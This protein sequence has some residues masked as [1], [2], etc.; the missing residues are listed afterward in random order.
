MKIGI[1]VHFEHSFF[2]NGNPTTAIS[3]A[4]AL[5]TLG[6]EPV[7]ININGTR[8]WYDDVE[9]LSKLYVRKN[10]TELKADEV[11][12]IV[13]DIDGYI[14][15]KERR[16]ISKSVVIFIRKSFF[17]T[18]SESCV[19]PKQLPKQNLYDCDMLWTW[20]HFGAEDA[21]LLE[22]LTKKPVV[23]IPFTWSS[24]PV[25][26]FGSNHPSWIS[27]SQKSKEEGW[28]IH[29]V[30]I[31]TS[32]T[33]NCTVPMVG[34][35]YA[36]THSKV[37]LLPVNI[38]S[39]THIE[40]EQFFKDNILAHCR[41]EGLEFKFLGR[42]RI[43]DFRNI[44]KS[45]VVLHTRFLSFKNVLLD[46]IWNG[47]PCIHNSPFIKSLGMG[48]ERSYYPDNSIVG[49]T[50][51]LN[52]IDEDY[53]NNSGIFTLGRLDEIR[54]MFTKLFDPIQHKKVW[55][56]AIGGEN[57]YKEI[58]VGFSDMY[59]GFNPEYNF[60]TVMLNEAGRHLHPPVR[61]RGIEINQINKT[62]ENIDILIAG[63]FYIN[64]KGVPDNIPKF[65]ITG[66]NTGCISEN[67]NFGFSKDGPKSIRFPLWIQY[68]DWFGADQDK[69]KNPRGLPI[70]TVTTTINADLSKKTK[71]CAFVV[72]NPSNSI[73][74]DAFH[75]LSSYKHVDSAG[76][77][78]NNMGYKIHSDFPGGGGGE[79]KKVEFLKDY[80][81]VITYEN[82]KGSGYVTEKLLA[83]KAAGCVPIYWGADEVVDD[84]P[85][86]SFINVNTKPIGAELI[87]AVRE[88]DNDD[89]KW[90]AMAKI[91]A[92]NAEKCR[93]LI[94][95]VARTILESIL[96]KSQLADLPE[97]LG[98]ANTAEANKSGIARGDLVAP[99]AE[100][101][102]GDL[103]A[104]KPEMNNV[105]TI[106][107][108]LPA[109]KNKLTKPN[110]IHNW[111]KKILLV[112]F[113]TQKYVEPLV[114]WFTSV[115][116]RLND[117]VSAR[118]Y[119]GKD[120]DNQNLNL[121]RSQYP[122]VEFYKVPEDE[123]VSSQF[124]DLWEAQHFAWKLWI[125]QELVH[126][127]ELE[128]TLVWYMDAAS[129]IVRWPT[130][131]FKKTAE[132][133]L[134]M[135]E[136]PEQKNDQWC[137]PIFCSKLGVTKEELGQ[138]QI[139][140]GIMSFIGGAIMPC[141]LFSEAWVLGQQRAIIV[142]P[143]WSGSLP[144]GR[145]YGHRHDQ[146]ILSIL[147]LRHKVPV[148]P[149][150]S[151]Y[152]DE[153]IRRTFKSGACLYIHRGNFKLN[154]NFA[155]RIGDAHI[156]NLE[157]RGDRI[158]RFKENHG[159]WRK[160]ICLRP[161]YDGLSLQLTP[162]IAKLFAPND[163]KWKKSIAGCALSHLSLWSE[164]ASEH[165]SCENYLILEDDVKF[166]GDWLATWNEASK[167]IPTDYDVLYLGGILPPNK[168][169]YDSVV[170]PV[171]RFWGRIKP[172]QLFGQGEPMP[173]FHFCNYSYI[174]SRNAAKK[175]VETIMKEG[176]TTS[177]D[178]MICNRMD[179]KHYVL[180][181]LVAGCYQ[182]DDPK[183]S[184]S[185]FNN[186]DRVD[187]FDSDLWNNDERF[188]QAEI[189]TALE[190]NSAFSISQALSDGKIKGNMDTKNRIFTV[191]EDK[192]IKGSL[193]EYDWLES[194]FGPLDKQQSLPINHEP[195][196]NSPIFF[197]K[198][199][200]FNEYMH[201][202][203]RY[204]AAGKTFYA[205]HISDELCNDPIEWYSLCK[206]VIRNY[207][208]ADTKSFDNVTYIPLGPCRTTK[209]V[210]DVKS[211]N[212]AWSFF[213]TG[214]LGRELKL[215]PLNG[216][217]PNKKVFY[218]KW[219]DSSQLQASEY[220]EQ[221][222]KT[223]FMPCPVGNNP[224]TFR[225]Y[226]AL[227]HGCIP[228]Y[229]RER[230]DDLFIKMLTS[231]LPIAIM[232]SWEAS[233]KFMVDNFQNTS[234]LV[235]YRIKLLEAW[236]VWKKKIMSDIKD[237]FKLN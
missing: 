24:K 57:N 124:P 120:V 209:L 208:R 101:L 47:I 203:S 189:Q 150:Y 46:C 48:L 76:Q 95:K 172:N 170:E 28:S 198:H 18:S 97:L 37:K 153:S 19:Y 43:T 79:L 193:L 237:K 10:F 45:V 164:L 115:T 26:H 229:V 119:L 102:H 221:C 143:K 140:G 60:W 44:P 156:I 138:Q 22:V 152:C 20:E 146:S 136:D 35:A 16:R 139:V 99:K 179:F 71:F 31:N 70:D 166:K 88:I 160:K 8:E 220:S 116:P 175:L 38:H 65:H 154:E 83:A 3:L 68:I 149:L 200:Y 182:D 181:P 225:I 87:N 23:R 63:P 201:V 50:S 204:A 36:K 234:M 207:P 194:L 131:W 206:H 199:P 226:E 215:F 158:Q 174:L 133:G 178:H 112:T 111:N 190:N 218:N 186:F 33:S 118:V 212:I 103:V 105:N 236:S 126:Q 210:N 177:A 90:L 127:A 98:G 42:L 214:W 163:F 114:K 92:I 192:L 72:S 151:V 123:V 81:F 40:S 93:K 235:D 52:N 58:I 161:A 227:E 222:L 75:T 96:D 173:Y 113:A 9:S 196:D 195:L 159:E 59:I 217:E 15:P 67:M 54:R 69:L 61:I 91:P 6:H 144:D 108:D 125:Y 165:E 39:S 41:R 104:P 5:K 213:G 64:W 17:L 185:E 11:F 129:M 2:S 183:Y 80:K 84:F 148:H 233:G 4:D 232:D 82:S 176:Y 34:I 224:E 55:E 109:I 147:R 130:E 110:K 21:H 25:E 184:S 14:I 13:I 74:N 29:N 122:N 128:N 135:L 51:A 107:L 12:D 56:K 188:S 231:N 162:S 134:C 141:K 219:A 7:L 168:I 106:N 62:T 142:G 94:S 157:R 171:N 66:E 228:I 216:I 53:K 78:F 211:R 27:I 169:M 85:A 30:E 155:P 197:C 32:I 202:F 205:V 230:G 49:M 223:I 77:L 73:R 191:G 117:D 180:T 137:H 100:I 132:S 89:K 145:P 1:F 121:L 86:D 187:K 167:E